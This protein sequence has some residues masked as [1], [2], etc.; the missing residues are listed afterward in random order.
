MLGGSWPGP[1][2]F[3]VRRRSRK[4]CRAYRRHF[5]LMASTIGS[6]FMRKF[7]MLGFVVAF[8]F[9]I[10]GTQSTA[11]E[12]K[13]DNKLIGT[14]KLTSA[15]YNGRESK[16]PEAATTLKHITPTQ[17]MWVSYDKDGK[18]LRAAGGTYT[19]EGDD[20]T[21]TPEYGMSADFDTVRGKTHTFKCK[22]ECKIEGTKWYHTGKLANGL[23]IDEIW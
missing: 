1:L 16:L 2:S 13:A 14:W 9:S 3:G 23:E 21:D 10:A 18:I 4:A 6:R 8:A 17:M 19:L 12:P 5:I 22:I 15:K 11:D 7:E 20:F